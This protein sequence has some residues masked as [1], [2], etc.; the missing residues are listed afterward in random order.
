M[1]WHLYHTTHAFGV[2]PHSCLQALTHALPATSEEV[3]PAA[4]MPACLWQFNAVCCIKTQLHHSLPSL[5]A[6]K[7]KAQEWATPLI[8]P[9]LYGYLMKPF[10]NKPRRIE[11]PYNSMRKLLKAVRNMLAARWGLQPDM[12]AAS[13]ISHTLHSHLLVPSH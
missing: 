10:M 6:G 1:L 4:H 5:C 13:W 12:P 2:S 3:W 9:D 8:N 11:L 7:D